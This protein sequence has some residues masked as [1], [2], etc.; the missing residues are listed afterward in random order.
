MLKYHEVYQP[1]IADIPIFG[2]DILSTRI[3]RCF[4]NMGPWGLQKYHRLMV[5]AM[6]G[7]P[8]WHCCRLPHLLRNKRRQECSSPLN[9]I[10]ATLLGCELI[11]T[12]IPVALI[13]DPATRT[14]ELLTL[15]FPQL[16]MWQQLSQAEPQDFES[17]LMGAPQKAGCDSQFWVTS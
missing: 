12:Y 16:S 7:K 13:D 1:I 17:L 10:L 8:P 3:H 15:L 2:I 5:E 11:S 14:L 6:L 9:S 4:L